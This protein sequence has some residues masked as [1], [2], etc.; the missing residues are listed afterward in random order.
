[1]NQ[2]IDLK[3][4]KT[5]QQ[6]ATETELY[7]VIIVVDVFFVAC[8]SSLHNQVDVHDNVLYYAIDKIKILKQQTSSLTSIVAARIVTSEKKHCYYKKKHNRINIHSSDI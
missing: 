2:R 3:K 1:M 4:T 5:E 7:L 6:T 8:P